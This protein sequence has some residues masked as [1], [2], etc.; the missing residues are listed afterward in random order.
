MNH[1]RQ[2]RNN[3]IECYFTLDAGPH[4]KILCQSEKTDAVV[5]GLKSLDAGLDILIDH[6]GTGV[7]FV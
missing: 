5:E 7:E 1:V 4:V 2:I 3:G 6:M